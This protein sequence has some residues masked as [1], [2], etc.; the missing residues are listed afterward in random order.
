MLV[1]VVGWLGLA[2]GLVGA[3]M[4]LA[5]HAT[6]PAVSAGELEWL[7]WLVGLGSLWGWR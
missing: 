1:V 5:L 4:L 2:L 6:M 7:W 3:P